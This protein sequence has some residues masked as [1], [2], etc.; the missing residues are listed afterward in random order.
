MGTCGPVVKMPSLQRSFAPVR[1]SRWRRKSTRSSRVGAE[2]STAGMSEDETSAGRHGVYRR[3]RSRRSCAATLMA[4]SSGVSLP[5][6]SPT[7]AWMR[8]IVR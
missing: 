3:L 5:I 2:V 1:G 4:I 7:G 6:S 8:S